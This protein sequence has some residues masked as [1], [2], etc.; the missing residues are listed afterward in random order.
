M[1]IGSRPMRLVLAGATIAW[2]IGVVLVAGETGISM[3][4]APA[5]ASLS[6]DYAE[7]AAANAER[8]A[9]M[10]AACGRPGYVLAA[11]Q[12]PSAPGSQMSEAA[13]KNIQVLKGIPVDE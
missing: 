1:R 13:F 10:A 3:R 6:T 9:A 12:A 4:A 2:L 7:R 5:Y 8:A 11:A